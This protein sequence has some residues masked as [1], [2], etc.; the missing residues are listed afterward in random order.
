VQSRRGRSLNFLF[1]ILVPS[2]MMMTI[3]VGGLIRGLKASERND[4][5]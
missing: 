5:V 3:Y 4:M 2:I 1:N